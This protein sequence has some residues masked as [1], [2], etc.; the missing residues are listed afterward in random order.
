MRTPPSFLLRNAR[1]VFPTQV[2]HAD[3][4]VEEGRIARIEASISPRPDVEI[5]DGSGKYVLPGF[6]DIHNH[7]ARG[8]DCSLGVF[9]QESQDFSLN[10][11]AYREGLARALAYY[12]EKGTTR[13]LCTSLAASL[14]E[15]ELSFRQIREFAAEGDHL[16]RAMIAGINVEGTFLKLPAYAGAQSPDFFYPPKK[17]TFERLQ[18]AS[19]GLIR[20][21]NLPPE[22]G[23]QGL[24]LIRYLRVQ[25][26]V[27]AAG[28]T[29]AEG[30][31]F[32]AAVAAG[33]RLAVHFLNGPSRSSSKAFH[34]GGAEEAMLR[35]DAVSL[36]LIVDGYHVH[37]AYVRDVIA[38]KG[39][40]RVVMITDSMF[41]NGDPDVTRFQLCGIP[42]AVSDNREYLQ[43]VDK[44]DT[45][46]GSVLTTGRGFENMINWLTTDMEG[47]WHR[48][49]EAMLLDEALVAASR[50][51]S[52][53]P[54]RLLG[55]DEDEYGSGAGTGSLEP[56]KWADLIVGEVR[57]S[58]G[59][60]RF[61]V[62]GVWLR[63]AQCFPVRSAL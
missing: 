25:G 63:G 41:V 5:F 49:H 20:I 31:E 32:E 51:A 57:E 55:I 46:F 19:G 60:Y 40:E 44:P 48:R 14:D 62:D 12:L 10:P 35:A 30:D 50:M 28:H 4:L 8:F 43:V 23:E 6:I 37:P 34:N 15:L 53:N 54:A 16:L 9:Q 59:G 1:L 42:G 58:E 29:G 21:V 52:G 7:G 11:S 22:H 38:R 61:E 33:T 3:L 26:V 24:E 17:E 13:V 56:G 27:A 2:I 45:L 39:V 18:N 47:I 36:E